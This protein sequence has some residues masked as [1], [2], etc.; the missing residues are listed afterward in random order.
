[1]VWFGLDL[2]SKLLNFSNN[3][4]IPKLAQFLENQSRIMFHI[5]VV[6]KKKKKKK[7]KNK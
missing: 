2:K 5:I 6:N 7:K 1:M 4:E 3:E